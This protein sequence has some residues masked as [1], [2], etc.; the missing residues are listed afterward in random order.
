[1]ALAASVLACGPT[2]PIQLGGSPADVEALAGEW[3][4]A[5][6]SRD[7]SREGTIW[8]KLVVGDASD[9]RVGRRERAKRR[10]PP[11]RSG[12]RGSP[13]ATV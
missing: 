13:R 7:S 6:T 9:L 8:F 11:E 10:E 4:G 2:P 3:T 12:A 1:M 5:Y